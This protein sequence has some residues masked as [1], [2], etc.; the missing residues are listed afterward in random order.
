M[1]ST[2]TTCSIL[3]KTCASEIWSDF[4]WYWALV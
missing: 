4:S 1:P 2:S 3:L